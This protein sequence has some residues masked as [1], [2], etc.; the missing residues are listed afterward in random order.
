MTQIVVNLNNGASVQTIRRAIALLRGVASTTLIKTKTA[1]ERMT[2]A[3][4]KI[5]ALCNM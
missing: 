3:Q 1:D 2:L 4:Q 5:V